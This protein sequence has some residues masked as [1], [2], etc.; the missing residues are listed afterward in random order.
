MLSDSIWALPG[1]SDNPLKTYMLPL[2][3][4]HSSLLHGILGFT[5]CHIPSAIM[6]SGPTV[7]IEHKLLAIQSL[8]SLLIK[9]DCLGLTK[10]EEDVALSI[11]L[12]LLLQDVGLPVPKL[13]SIL[14]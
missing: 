11:V 4:E 12:L 14:T 10:V 7:A 2:A 3:Y 13:L 1:S 8:S 6:S 5:A 9:E